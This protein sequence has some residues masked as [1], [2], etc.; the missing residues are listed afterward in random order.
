[1]TEIRG[2]MLNITSI[3]EY[4][5]WKCFITSILDLRIQHIFTL[6]NIIQTMTRTFHKSPTVFQYVYNYIIIIST[7]Y[8][9]ANRSGPFVVFTFST[10]FIFHMGRNIGRG[11]FGRYECPPPPNHTSPAPHT[12]LPPIWKPYTSLH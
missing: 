5:N 12:P 8:L 3:L 1:M 2:K 10:P 6:L 9:C 11:S 4:N 7:C